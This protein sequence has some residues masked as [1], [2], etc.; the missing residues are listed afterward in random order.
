MLFLPG[1]AKA[2]LPPQAF[3]TLKSWIEICAA[4]DKVFLGMHQPPKNGDEVTDYGNVIATVRELASVLGLSEQQ[5]YTLRRRAVIQSLRAKRPNFC[6]DPASG[7]MSSTSAARI[8]KPRA[9]FIRNER[10]KKRPTAS[11]GKSC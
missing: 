11:S 7:V 9:I 8:A 4:S 10:S 1:K 3:Q 2:E 6:W 5:I